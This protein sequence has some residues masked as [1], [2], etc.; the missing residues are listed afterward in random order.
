MKAMNETEPEHND[1]VN[2]I[3]LNLLQYKNYECSLTLISFVSYEFVCNPHGE[4]D[5]WFD[6]FKK[7]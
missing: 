3:E 4:V 1:L 7:S 6:R 2:D 5:Q